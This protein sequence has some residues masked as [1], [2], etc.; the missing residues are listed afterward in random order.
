MQKITA[1]Y[2]IALS[3]KKFAEWSV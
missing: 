1:I 3:W 2:Y